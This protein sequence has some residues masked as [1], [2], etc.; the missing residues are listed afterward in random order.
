MGKNDKKNGCFHV[1]RIFI[2]H[3]GYAF[4]SVYGLEKDIFIPKNKTEQALGGDKVIVKIKKKNRLEGQVVYLLDIK[5]KYYLGTLSLA[6][7]T[8]YGFVQADNNYI[9]VDIFISEK[10]FNKAKNKDK[11][12]V[13]W[14]KTST[15]PNIIEILGVSGFQKTEISAI[16]IEYGWPSRKVEIESKKIPEKISLEEIR[17]RRDLRSE[18]TF[19]V[20]PFDAKDFDDALSL[21][22]LGE[23]TWEIGVHISDVS[24]YLIEGSLLDLEASKRATS[25]YFVDFVVPMLPK[26]LSNHLCS[27][28]PNSERLCFSA[29]FE[30][31]KKA[32]LL[33]SWFGKTIIKSY[34]RFTY[35]E[36]QEI[37]EKY[38]GTFFEEILILE[39]LAQKLRKERLDKGSINFNKSEIKFILDGHHNPKKICLK[40]NKMA[41]F[42]IEEFMLLANKKVSEFVSIHVKKKLSTYIY[43][44]HDKPNSEKLLVLKK[45]I[46]TLGYTINLRN[47]KTISYS[48]N[49]LLES[50]KNKPEENLIITFAMQ[51]MSK[52]KYSTNN[53]GHYG[54]FFDY[55]SHFTSPIRRYS[56]IMAHRLLDIYLKNG[57]SP[58]KEIYEKKAEHCSSKEK[59]AYEVERVYI[60]YMQ[61]KYIECIHGNEFEGIISG[62]N[63]FG[64]SVELEIS[65]AI[66]KV[67][68]II[69]LRNMKDDNYAFYPTKYRVIGEK[70]GRSYHL[71]QRVLVKVEEVNIEKR[72]INFQ[73][74]KNLNN[75]YNNNSSRK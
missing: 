41:N 75:E 29:I 34:K 43:R 5:K 13:E 18:I 25:I 53:I 65:K 51:A 55:Y 27:L 12:I 62:F 30:I 2:T 72:T 47:R 58:S 66:S 16:L 8:S 63:E 26:I 19:T 9:N 37:I 50:V 48:M 6:K 49:S 44:V 52:A 31:N 39:K 70:Y 17:L 7:T 28:L 15:Q 40:K 69:L 1:G 59:I 42:V 32:K 61:L 36:V 74:K 71:G 64:I 4:V 45:I 11:V 14:E 22:K 23:N 10:N 57:K 54:L 33:K 38:S 46:K 68:G 21:K 3:F 67:E 60:K 24:Y 20:D 35:A 56:D 73:L